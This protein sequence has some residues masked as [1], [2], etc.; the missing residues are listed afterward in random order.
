MF[1]R[2]IDFLKSQSITALMTALN[3]PEQA[4]ETGLGISSI[5]DTWLLLRDIE[6]GGERNRGIYVLK[7]RGMANSNQIREFLITSDGIKLQDVCISADGV[8]TGSMRVMHEA[9]QRAELAERDKRRTEELRALEQRRKTIKAQIEAL[10][11]E[12]AAADADAANK[13]NDD[14]LTQ[15]IVADELHQ[16]ALSRKAEINGEGKQTELHGELR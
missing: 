15:R 3:G 10:Q 14:R 11:D 13:S 5:V 1:V 4:E 8:L 2:L 16:L 6:L 7:S 12:L 9:R